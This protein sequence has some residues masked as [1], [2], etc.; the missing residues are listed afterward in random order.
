MPRDAWSPQKAAEAGRSLPWALWREQVL[1]CLDF[2]AP[3][4][5]QAPRFQSWGG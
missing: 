1:P 2:R 3:P 4:G 5:S